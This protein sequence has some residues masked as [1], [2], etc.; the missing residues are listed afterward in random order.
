[1]RGQL[2]QQQIMFIGIDD[3]THASVSDFG[4][5]LQHPANR[6]KL[7]FDLHDDGYDVRDHQVGDKAP[8]RPDMENAG[9]QWRRIHGRAA[10]G[11]KA[12]QTIEGQATKASCPHRS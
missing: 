1:M 3:N 11:Q 7:T 6:Q 5:Y 4:K 2:R 9:W 12:W 10:K 8:L